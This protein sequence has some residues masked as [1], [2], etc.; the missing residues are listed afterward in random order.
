MSLDIA[1]ISTTVVNFPE[2]RGLII[3]L[4]KVRV[5]NSALLLALA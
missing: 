3:S 5:V 1:T 4:L 2:H